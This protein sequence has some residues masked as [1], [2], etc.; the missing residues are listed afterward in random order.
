MFATYFELFKLLAIDAIF[1]VLIA[2]LL[3]PLAQ[4]KKAAFAVLK[5]NFVGYFANPT[6]YVF[7]CLFVFL[8][9]AAAFW[10]HDF[11]IANLANL[12]QLNKYIPLILLVFVPAITMSL[13]ADERRQGTDELL[14]TL[15]AADFDI[16]IGKYL[17]AA[18]IYTVSLM[19]SQLCNFLLLVHVASDPIEG[20]VDIDIGLFFVTYLGYWL[21]GL[22]MLA[23]GMVASFLTPNLTVSFILGA[24]FNA[25]PVMTY[26]SDV[27]V[28]NSSAARQISQWSFAA[29]FDDFGRGVIS[30]SSTAF[31]VLIIILGVYLS[32]VLIGKR[33]WLRHDATPVPMGRKVQALAGLLIAVPSLI[34]L[35]LAPVFER[36]WGMIALVG[37]LLGTGI[38]L[39]LY[40]AAGALAKPAH[41]GSMAAH[42]L[43]RSITLVVV[44]IAGNLLLKQFDRRYDLTRG[45]VSSLSPDTRRL[46]REVAEKQKR[47]IYVDA[48]IS[49]FVPEEYVKTRYSLVSMLK[50]LGVQSGGR[51]NVRLHDN[52]ELFST[53]AANAEKRF[54]IQRQKITSQS[55]GA[56]K[57]EDFIMGVAF[58]CGLEKVVLPSF[59]L[60]M[61]VEYELVRSIVTVAGD[62]RKKLGVVKTDAEMMGGFSFQGMQ[63]RQIPKQLILEELEKQY[64]VEEVDPANPIELG[65]YDALLIVQPSTLGPPQLA[66]VVDA[67]KKGQP[68]VIFED[69]FPLV[70]P[71][72]VGTTQ[73]KP[74]A[75]GMFGM[76]GGPQ[77][78]GD[79]GA[80]WDALE[81]QVTGDSR[82]GK[83]PGMRPTHS[84]VI[85]QDYN[86]Y[87]KF[88]RLPNELVFVRSGMP[89]NRAP[90]NPEMPVVS[91]FEEVL[92]PY[93]T[94]ISQQMGAKL[95][96]T[97]LVRTGE[98][99]SGTIDVN[100]LQATQLDPDA[101]D[102]E[103]GRPSKQGYIIGAWIRG[104]AKTDE[105]ETG[106][107]KTVEIK[108]TSTTTETKPGINTIYVGD[109]DVLSSEFVRM[110]N[111]PNL[112][113]A[114]FHFDNV[115]FVCNLIDAVA[116]ETRFLEIRKRKPRHSTLRLVEIR[117]SDARE[118]QKEANIK[119]QK[120]YDDLV[121]K[122]DE[123]KEK[124]FADFKKT[125]D[126]LQRKQQQGEEVDQ[127]KLRAAALQLAMRQRIAERTAEVTKERLRRERDQV[128]A[129]IERDRDQQIQQ[130]QNEYKVKATVL[131]PILPLLVG[132]VVWAR[133]RIREREGVS[134]SRM[135]L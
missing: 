86:P 11:F 91:N 48:Y 71:Q 135:R 12:D 13:W 115:P 118:Q 40:W 95:K 23:I 87:G 121:K 89:D 57:E 98:G 117:A 116:G 27:L 45:Q 47:P 41:T 62:Q 108:P 30:L 22:A 124:D 104:D 100:K 76:G 75:G 93:P 119:K 17:A 49:A 44:L 59:K 82:S 96:M 37:G 101:L 16:V 64:K 68:S 88:Q 36:D 63:P 31:F 72:A 29:Q 126:D 24:L 4:F 114:R 43:V 123:E 102:I 78:K 19:F 131:P 18:A 84:E 33:H 107:A 83:L 134:R 56:L 85:W 25:I 52:L 15:P 3:A 9:S 1:V 14:L 99:R 26:Y 105:S 122:A 90:F 42:F 65:R 92:F 61:P 129:E 46:L 67:V 58:T 127:E 132:L 6:G 10:P 94:G 39:G 109:I 70:M 28:P 38:G 106:D 2:L 80:L 32:M 97:E 128:L 20:V 51:V 73:E 21:M 111:E 5:R 69:P 74:P 103:R 125:Y 133:R 8:T 55:R 7:L 60:G 35:A 66:N 113:V 34:A 81:I 50:E 110:R 79:I 53:E 54:G 120:E 112:M 130:I 77:P